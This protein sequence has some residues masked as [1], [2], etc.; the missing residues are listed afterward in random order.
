[1]YKLH[2]HCR[3]CGFAKPQG[4]PGIKSVPSK[5]KLIE[6]FDLGLQPLANDFRSDEEEHAG[7][8]PLKVLMCPKCSLAQL[9]VV[10]DPQVLY[11]NYSYVTSQSRT[12]FEHFEFLWDCI[13]ESFNPENILEIGSNDGTFLKFLMDHGAGSVLGI[14]PA[15]NLVDKANCDGIRSLCGCFDEESA[16]S[17]S[18]MMP[19][20]DVVVARHVFCHTDDWQAFVKNL[21]LVC[22]KDTIVVIEVPYVMDLIKNA[23][24]DT[25]YHEHLSYMNI[26]AMVELL[27]D[28]PFELDYVRHVPIQAGSVL[29]F[30]SRR[31]PDRVVSDVIGQYVEEENKNLNVSA[32][33]DDFADK[34]QS[35]VWALKDKLAQ[36]RKAG[37]TVCGFG[38]SAK[39]SVWVNA[40]GFTRSDLRFIADSTPQKHYKKS[41]GSD[42][43]IVDEGA[44][45]RELP[46]YAVCWAWNFMPEILEKNK[47]YIE[48]GG[49]FI[50]PVP[51]VKIVPE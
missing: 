35:N 8:A 10:V 38:A 16:R 4:P 26:K 18:I 44:L 32:W 5:E 23:Q 43:P 1:M 45:L 22:G 51:Q 34:V 12:M 27:R 20:V 37:K 11:A 7:F 19:S 15:L 36:L 6:V 14:D 30:I 25:I 3:A 24:F 48:N 9:S 2:N 46:D 17:A 28:T 40:C 49:R 42:I 41:P 31:E 29:L 50:V 13:R 21:D 33:R 39:S 47:L